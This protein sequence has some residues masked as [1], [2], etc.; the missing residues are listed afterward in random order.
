MTFLNPAILFGIFAA[1]IPI[2]LH[3]LNLRKLKKIEF[4]TL[5]FL[6]ELQKTKIRRIKLKQWLLLLLRILI[7]VFLV[8]AFA[9]PTVK[10]FSVGN[11]SAA[12]TT[13]VI[14]IDNTFSMSVVSGNGSYL[15]QAKHAA[16][17]L[18]GNFQQGDEV[19]I[20]PISRS[21]A[22]IPNTSTNF[23]QVK[24]S[25][26]EIELSDI[27][28]T[29]NNALIN[30]AK[31]I[32]ESKN[33][34][35]EIYLLTDCQK[36]RLFN[37]E[38]ELSNFGKMFGDQTRI[39]LM[40]IG[41]KDVLNLGIESLTLNNQIFEVGKTITLSAKI[42]NYSK[43][44]VSDNLLSLFIKGKRSAQ[45]N[46]SLGSGE[47]REISFETN[48]SDTGLVDM[49]AELED[50]DIIQ[51]NSRYVLINIPS[52]I[53]IAA[54][55]NRA[56]DLRFI[57]IALGIP[58]PKYNYKE[59]TLNQ[60]SSLNLSRYNL[61]LIGGSDDL[62]PNDRLINYISRGGNVIFFPG[63]QSSLLLLQNFCGSLGIPKPTGLIGKMNSPE[64]ISQFG[65]ID[66]QHP[67]LKDL[68][69]DEKKMQIQSPEILAYY[70]FP[71]APNMKSIISLIDGSPFLS[72]INVGKGRVLFFN[73]PLVL[74]WNDL[75]LKSVFAPLINKLFLYSSVK[76]KNEK[77]ILAGDEVEIDISHSVSPRIEV[78]R[79]NLN[80]EYLDTDS[81]LN[82]NF[83][84]YRSAD[85]I[86]NYRI[87]S[88]NILVD[89]FSVNHDS[90]ESATNKY[91]LP[92]FE[93]YAE[94]IGYEGKIIMLG[95]D[96]DFAKVIYQSRFG[97]E[98][99]KY[100]ILL[101]IILAIVESLVA[102]SSKKDMVQN[103]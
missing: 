79:P 20:L 62:T 72:E 68:F 21:S 53:S 22:Y 93:K 74:G 64:A 82:K 70:R 8:M 34:N 11:S 4:S 94:Q 40:D 102:R 54:F 92:D 57:R 75:P 98:L 2:L 61:I 39:Y 29:I 91:S 81:L 12:K 10:S 23:V 45:S 73:S 46:I 7:I 25:I 16:K 14:I 63:S 3:F 84:Y 100:F 28:G 49:R 71:T 5:A 80:H 35:K 19:A 33:Y 48:L 43:Q 42:R 87:T 55:N 83:I 97:T 1:A 9:R 47:A 90:R 85:E 89:Y 31:L 26:G 36:S 86:G 67:L 60:I 88:G 50:D 77:D 76:L 103:H 24:K 99:W 58:N 78:E 52:N 18:L 32:F 6:K 17:S 51:D 65:K 13:A 56:D 95:P 30:A 66:F 44:S 15:N 69:Q 96:S 27:S 59:F 38:S 37:S 101:V 41:Q